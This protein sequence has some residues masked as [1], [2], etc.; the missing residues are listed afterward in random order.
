[1]PVD[2][3]VGVVIMLASRELFPT[4]VRTG[5]AWGP[6]LVTD[7]HEGGLIMFAGS[8][9]IMVAL[10]MILAVS[11]VRAREG[12]RAVVPVDLDAYLASLDKKNRAPAGGLP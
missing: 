5:R 10:A 9:L 2:T 4:Y 1:M 11:L 12:A 6:G 8:D 7:L 3:L